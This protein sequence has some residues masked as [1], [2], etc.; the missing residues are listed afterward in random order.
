MCS[1]P[2]FKGTLPGLGINEGDL[3]GGYPAVAVS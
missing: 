3:Y 1:R 2:D